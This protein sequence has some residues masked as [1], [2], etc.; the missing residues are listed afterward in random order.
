M[1]ILS[2][3]ISYMTTALVSTALYI[4]PYKWYYRLLFG[5]L[6]SGMCF[7]FGNT[8]GQFLTPIF[9]MIG[10]ILTFFTTK[11]RVLNITLFQLGWFWMVISDYMISVPMWIMGYPISDI[12]KSGLLSFCCSIFHTFISFIPA[13]FLAKHLR[14]STYSKLLE[15]PFKAQILLC[16]DVSICCCIY[17]FN[18]I[19]G[20]FHNYEQGTVF[21]N[22]LLF[23]FYLVCNLIIFYFLY[24]I[25]SENKQLALEAK[26]KEELLSYTENLESLYENMRVFRH[27]Y[28]NILSTM[29]YYIDAENSDELKKYFNEK[30]LPCSSSI[31]SQNTI[32]GKLSRIKILEIKS[33]IYTKIIKAIQ[34]NLNISLELMDDI[35]N[36]FMDSFKL[37][38]ILGILLDN[39]IEAASASDKKML[40]LAIVY[41]D[42]GLIIHISN[43]TAPISIPIEKMFDEGYS[44]KG[45]GHCGIGLYEVNNIINELSHVFIETTYKNLVFTQELEIYKE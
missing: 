31:T 25:M 7:L 1:L 36:A 37:C 22:G 34:A 5:L 8:M 26:A 23:T 44:S 41:F 4:K 27:D 6:F 9:L 45:N 16:I 35:D 10:I 32:I 17:V 12:Q 18:I 19:Y 14:K 43:S 13:L 29:K 11:N 30:I 21:Y 15:I 24:H 42:N 3:L 28:I 33:I 38:T 40:R 20:S 2:Q 39:A